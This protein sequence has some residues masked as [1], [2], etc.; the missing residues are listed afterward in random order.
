[1]T[2]DERKWIIWG[3]VITAVLMVVFVIMMSDYSP[4]Y[5]PAGSN[6]DALIESLGTWQDN[7]EATSEI[8]LNE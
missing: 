6:T 1:M 3:T 7:F 2:K 8:V 5:H 4:L